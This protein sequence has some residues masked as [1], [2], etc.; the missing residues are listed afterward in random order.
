MR[1]WIMRGM[2]VGYVR[3]SKREQNPDLQRRELAAAGCEKI[4]EER[5]S[6]REQVRPQLEAALEYCREGDVLV[7]WKLDRLGRSIKELIGLVNEL[8]DRGVG[9]RSL[10]ESLDTTTPGG[11]L[12]FHVFASIAE[13][14]RDVIRERT[15]AGLEAARARGR[16]GGRKPVMDERKISLASSLMRDRANSVQDV[17]ETLGISRATL[18]R[19]V[20]P[21]GAP[22]VVEHRGRK[23]AGRLRDERV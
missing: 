8:K 6:S 9:F 18:Y 10:R 20:A 17:C 21:D 11:K 22:R 1:S 14:E 3:V 19:Y 5:I 2:D 12:V 15:M 16:K 7:V 13:F 4:F 23:E